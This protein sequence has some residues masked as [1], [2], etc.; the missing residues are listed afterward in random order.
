MDIGV[1]LLALAMVYLLPGPDMILLLH[2]GAREGVRAALS[3]ALGLALARACHV[4]LAATGLALLFR[5]APWTFDAVR[6]VG[7][8]YLAW[9]GL[10]LLRAPL[11]PPA[12]ATSAPA[13]AG[14][15][16]RAFRRGLLT[17]LLNPK[18]LLFCSV[19]LPQFIQP[20]NG[21]LML[22]FA[23]LGGVLVVVGLG[24][25][26]FYAISGER[27]GR[28]LARHRLMQRLQ[29][30]GFGGILLGFGVRLAL[31]RDL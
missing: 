6:V 8:L 31:V 22:Q 14:A 9:I 20:Q 1:F 19:L 21:P 10:R 28:W 12:A 15:G 25:D 7:G 16:W 24:F 5:T 27:M 3:T 23:L 11:E 4:A 30:W 13:I 18:A 26:A 2:T 29:Q 17:N